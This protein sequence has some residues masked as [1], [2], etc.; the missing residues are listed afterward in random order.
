MW[1]TQGQIHSI[2]KSDNMAANAG[3]SRAYVRSAERVAE[4]ALGPADAVRDG[5]LSARDA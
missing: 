2:Y 5:F 4:A 1:S 3:V